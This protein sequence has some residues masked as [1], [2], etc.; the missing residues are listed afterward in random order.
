MH[1]DEFIKEQ[2]IAL[3]KFRQSWLRKNR[4]AP[5]DY[6]A[7]LDPGGWDEQF[8]MWGDGYPGHEKSS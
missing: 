6:P 1:I 7:N 3:F 4:D 2:R 8:I 5:L